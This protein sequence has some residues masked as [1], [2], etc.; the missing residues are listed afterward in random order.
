MQLKNAR[1]LF[2]LRVVNDGTAQFKLQ[3]RSDSRLQYRQMKR[4]L[5]HPNSRTTK[6]LR[7]TATS[8]LDG[9]K[10]FWRDISSRVAI[11]S[12]D[13]STCRRITRGAQTSG[14]TR[15][16]PKVKVNSLRQCWKS[17]AMQGED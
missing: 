17:L 14:E 1:A 7:T 13:R 15:R 3:V 4:S 16:A 6:R 8:K 12:G 9:N 10:T 5:Q 2:G 11:G